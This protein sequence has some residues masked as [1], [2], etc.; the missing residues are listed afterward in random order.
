MNSFIILCGGFGKRFQK[1]STTLPKI[2]IEIDKG[3]SMLDWLLNK[4]LPQNSKVI[5]AT[6]HLNEEIYKYVENKKYSQELLIVEE[7]K[8]LGTGGALINASRFVESEEFIALNGDTIQEL[9]I[10]SF[11]RNSQLRNDFIINVGCTKKNKKDSG[12]IL[13]NKDNIIESFTEK[14]SPLK[15][16]NKSQELVTSLGIYR[17]KTSFFLSEEISNISL[18]ESLIPELVKIR[19][20]K[21]S[22]FM[23][24]FQDFWTYKRYNE[25]IN[26]RIN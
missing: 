7:N 3:I 16:D 2:L 18:E 5:L 12:M 4:Y 14:I 17:C 23:E 21:A 24:D 6:G 8:P 1:V 25:Y 10:S 26:N 20:A 9:K 11:L 15:I 13:I 22:I 19:K